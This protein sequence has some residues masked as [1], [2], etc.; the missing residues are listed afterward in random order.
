MTLIG[1]LR[2]GETQW[3]LER[4]IQGHTDVPLTE[5]ARARLA[6]SCTPEEWRRVRV[7]CSP[8]ARC[9]ETAAALELGSVE[10]DGRLIEMRWGEW[11]GRRVA[12]LRA[13]L[14]EAMQSNE[15]RGW[16][17]QPPGG[18]SPRM[19]FE[20]VRGFLAE[21]RAAGAPVLA[22][23]HRGVMQSVFARAFGWDMLGRAPVKLDWRAIQV[24][25]AGE[26]GAPD[27]VRLNL[28]LRE[29]N[30]CGAAR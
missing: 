13:E 19:V 29:K 7:V 1:F 2:H 25:C 10:V 26:D 8:L 12:D 24:F 17:F 22:I 30:A 14:G 3:N 20:R 9:I 28:A 5:S 6:A 27:V 11:E 21:V 23:S 16:D 15:D 4:R 18:E